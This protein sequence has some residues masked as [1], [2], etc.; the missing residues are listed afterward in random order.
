[1]TETA[2]LRRC[3]ICGRNLLPNSDG[4]WVP[5]WKCDECRQSWWVAELTQEARRHFRRD[6]R[7]FG[8]LGSA[9]YLVVRTAVDAEMEEAE[10]R[11]VSVRR[12][13]LGILPRETLSGLMIRHP[14]IHKDFVVHMK[15]QAER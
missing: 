1:M 7:D 9:G 12:E 5:P 8:V 4:W 3:P 13:Q 6:Q 15:Q 2:Y 11:G 14:L 10:A